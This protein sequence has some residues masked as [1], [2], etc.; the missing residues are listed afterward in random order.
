M[1][2]L[3]KSAVSLYPKDLWASQFYLD[4]HELV[5]RRLK[6][7]LNAQGTATNPITFDALGFSNVVLASGLF[8][9]TNSKG[10]PTMIDP[11]N[12]VIYLLDTTVATPVA[13]DVTT[14]AAY[15]TVIGELSN[16]PSLT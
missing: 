13:V 8:D 1:A 5:V 6:L 9:A 3:A 4:R 14:S 15:I 2:K 16:N 7:V 12:N 11:V 10:Y